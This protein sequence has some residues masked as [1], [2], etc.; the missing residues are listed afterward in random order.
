MSGGFKQKSEVS[1]T[2]VSRWVRHSRKEDG[3]P[4]VNVECLIHPLTRVV[5]T[6]QLRR[7][8]S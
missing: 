5:L 8:E 6:S 1:T 4:C 3:C 7:N 2:C